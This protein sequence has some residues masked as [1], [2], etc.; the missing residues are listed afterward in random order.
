MLIN[1]HVIYLQS[2]TVSPPNDAISIE[3]RPTKLQPDVLQTTPVALISYTGSYIC[4]ILRGIFVFVL[5]RHN[6]SD[7]MGRP[8]LGFV[9]A[10]KHEE[11]CNR[12]HIAPVAGFHVNLRFC[13][14]DVVWN[15]GLT[16][17]LPAADLCV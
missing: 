7:A 17:K 10:C 6:S 11:L 3:F 5:Q 4:K 2:I 9:T 1:F 14:A 13:T 12:E 16:W 15:E 8:F